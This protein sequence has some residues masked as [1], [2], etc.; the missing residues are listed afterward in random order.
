MAKGNNKEIGF[1]G[2]AEWSGMI[3]EDFIRELRGK[4]GYKRFNEMR[5]NSPIVGALLYA[6]EQSIRSL[7][8]NYSSSEGEDDPR[9]EFLQDALSGMSSNWNDHISEALSMLPFGYAPF[10]IVYERKNGKLVW[11]K[12]AFR[13]QD[14]VHRWLFD[15]NGG[16]EGFEQRAMPS[17]YPVTI[18]IEKLVLYRTR[19]EKN[20]PEGRSLLRTAWIPYYYVKNIQQIEAIGVERDL[21]GLPMIKLPEG[22]DTSEGSNSDAGK[23]KQLVRNVRNDEQAGI[24]VPAGWEFSLVST[25]GTRSFDT[26]KIIRRYESRILMSALAQFLILGQDSVGTQALSSDLTDFWALSVNAI[27]DAIADAHTKYAAHKL[28]RLNGMEAEGISM[29]HSPAGDYNLSEIGSFLQQAGNK[30]TW[31]AA[32]E[33]WLRGLAR[34]PEVDLDILEEERERIREEKAAQAAFMPFEADFFAAKG[35]APDDDERRKQEGRL[36]RLVRAYWKDYQ[37]RL[38]EEVQGK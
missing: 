19:V 21:A 12:F 30:I 24:V 23:A 1:S 25:G 13:S 31:M 5:L 7:S 8:W 17:L 34:L 3:A 27:A 6:I 18:P 26:D 28:L 11:R 20:N 35:E 16:L 33:Q 9:I 22:A 37:D 10:E 32:D 4:Q 14:T 2:L 15:D 38:I 36:F 29:Q